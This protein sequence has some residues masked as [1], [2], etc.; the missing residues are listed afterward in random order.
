MFF[1]PMGSQ[2]PVFKANVSSEFLWLSVL[3]FFPTRKSPDGHV[4]E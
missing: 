4:V 3:P 2:G 1:D